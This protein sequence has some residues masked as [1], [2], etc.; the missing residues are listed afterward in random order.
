MN[1]QAQFTL[2]KALLKRCP[3]VE[4]NSFLLDRLRKEMVRVWGTSSPFTG[5]KMIQVLE[6]HLST[7]SIETKILENHEVLLSVLN[8]YRLMLMK[9]AK[10]GTGI[11]TTDA[12]FSLREKLEILSQI[13]ESRLEQAAK[14]AEAEAES[15]P[16]REED[17]GTRPVLEVAGMPQIS[18]AEE[19]QA[20]AAIATKLMLTLD[21]VG[22]VLEAL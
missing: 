17:T 2:I 18:Q 13:L 12:K 10:G 6:H 4:V 1:D 22:R 9:D 20:A 21:L 8:T 3:H 7:S 16:G 11:W 19:K 5:E 15:T 14:D